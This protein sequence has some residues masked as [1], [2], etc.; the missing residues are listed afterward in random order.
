MWYRNGFQNWVIGTYLPWQVESGGCIMWNWSLISAG[1]PVVWSC[2]PCELKPPSSFLPSFSLSF[3]SYFSTFS[4]SL[5]PT[6]LS[7][8][9]PFPPFT[10]N[11]VVWNKS[12]RNFLSSTPT[13]VSSLPF[14]PTVSLAGFPP[15]WHRK[16]LVLL[17][18]IMEGKYEFVS[19]EWDDISDHAKDLVS[20]SVCLDWD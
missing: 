9:S 4:L 7:F 18:S 8:T 11:I 13:S 16:Q 15:F 19:P 20:L 1:G 3:S 5:S 2:T 17:R 14:P 12:C 6:H 10:Q